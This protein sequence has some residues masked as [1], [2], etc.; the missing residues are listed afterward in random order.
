MLFRSLQEALVSATEHSREKHQSQ[1]EL[2]EAR[3]ELK[4]RILQLLQS[5]EELQK[6]FN[7][8]QELKK[9]NQIIKDEEMRASKALRE[10]QSSTSWRISYPIRW[11][12][13]KARRIN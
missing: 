7:E 11:A 13:D 1:A 6:Y 8:S 3:E 9:L 12:L 5:Q 2:N 10:I 4:L